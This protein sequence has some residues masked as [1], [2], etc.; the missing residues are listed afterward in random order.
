M[1]NVLLAITTLVTNFN[2][3]ITIVVAIIITIAIYAVS[4]TIVFFRNNIFNIF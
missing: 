4:A 1:S 2:H 3:T